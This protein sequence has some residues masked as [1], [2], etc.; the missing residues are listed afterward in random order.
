MGQTTNSFLDLGGI[1]QELKLKELSCTE[2][3]D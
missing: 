2:K 3:L 1:Q